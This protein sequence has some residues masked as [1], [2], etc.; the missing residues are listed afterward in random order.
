MILPVHI[1]NVAE[2]LTPGTD[3][4]NK[5]I[6]GVPT[7]YFRNHNTPMLPRPLSENKL[8]LLERQP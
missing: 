6:A 4:D 7:L 1:A 8:S 2:L 5:E 3:L